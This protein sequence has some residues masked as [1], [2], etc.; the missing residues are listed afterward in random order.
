MKTDRQVKNILQQNK[1]GRWNICMY[2]CIHLGDNSGARG[3]KSSSSSANPTAPLVSLQR[4]GFS[5][6]S[7]ATCFYLYFAS[8]YLFWLPCDFCLLFFLH[9]SPYH[10]DL[11]Q[12]LFPGRTSH[13]FLYHNKLFF[14]S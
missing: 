11:T 5:V 9:V 12:K 1:D 10:S 7:F 6:F 2:L 4:V 13:C 8:N 14:F 3:Q